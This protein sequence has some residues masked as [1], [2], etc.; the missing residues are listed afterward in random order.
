MDT[1]VP[2]VPGTNDDVVRLKNKK[3][4]FL[5]VQKLF[6]IAL[7]ITALVQSEPLLAAIPTVII[8]FPAYQIEIRCL[9]LWIEIRTNVQITTAVASDKIP[10]YLTI[11]QYYFLFLQP[12]WKG[13][14]LLLY[15]CNRS[16]KSIVSHGAISLWLEVLE[17]V[18]QCVD[19]GDQVRQKKGKCFTI[20]RYNYTSSNAEQYTVRDALFSRVF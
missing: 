20:C 11:C 16:K 9:L 19:Q 13:N 15:C 17:S 4:K 5:K 7:L 8:T 14:S 12:N 3:V 6:L 18:K 10:E 1:T 2:F